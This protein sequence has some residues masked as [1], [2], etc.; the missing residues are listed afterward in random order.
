MSKNNIKENKE[1]KE[2]DYSKIYEEEVERQ[3]KVIAEIGKEPITESNYTNKLEC[4]Q[5][6][7]LIRKIDGEDLWEAEFK[8]SYDRLVEKLNPDEQNNMRIFTNFW[9]LGCHCKATMEELF[10]QL[11]NW[12]YAKYIELEDGTGTVI[13]KKPYTDIFLIPRIDIDG[14]MDIEKVFVISN[15]VAKKL[16]EC[17]Q[18]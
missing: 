11:E 9:Q 8:N 10:Q 13:C 5:Q 6:E 3:L 4:Q 2:I 7:F 18:Q 15:E 17:F 12:G 1:I 16:K 14:D